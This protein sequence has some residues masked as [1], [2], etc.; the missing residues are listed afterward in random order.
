M[1][2]NFRSL[3]VVLCLAALL[4][5]CSAQ[6][7]SQAPSATAIVTATPQPTEAVTPE[8]TSTPVIPQVVSITAVPD[9]SVSAS[10]VEE[11]FSTVNRYAARVYHPDRELYNALYRAVDQFQPTLDISG[12]DLSRQQ[13]LGTCESLYVEGQFRFFYLEF[14]KQSKD[15]K[16]ITFTYRGTKEEAERGKETFYAKF[17]HLLHNVARPDGTDLQKY[18]AVYQYLCET[19]SYSSDMTDFLT[20]SPYSILVKGQGICDGYAMLMTVALD[21]LGVPVKYIANT[22]HAWNIVTIDNK[23][24]HGDVTWGAGNTTDGLNKLDTALMDDAARMEGLRNAG[25]EK[26]EI[27]IG[28]PGDEGAPAVPV[29][30]STSFQAYRDAVYYYALDTDGQKIYFARGYQVMSMNLDCTDEAVLADQPAGRMAFYHGTLYFVDMNDGFLYRLKPGSKPEVVDK[31]GYFTYLNI[32]RGTHQYGASSEPAGLKTLR[33]TSLLPGEPES[34]QVSR[35]QE[36]VVPR[37]RSFSTQIRFSEP[38]DTNA[39][40]SELVYLVD[41]QGDPIPLHFY[42]SPDGTTLTVRPRECVADEGA[43]D[44]YLRKEAP[45][46]QGAVMEAGRAMRIMIQAGR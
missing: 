29:C 24:Y 9:Q 26:E 34:E 33:L 16:T 17:S 38:M 27:M 35:L 45:S 2:R 42:W 43:V 14:A 7:H 3:L 8:P 11:P 5:G 6:V 36:A 19:S 31:S 39:D 32:H 41:R 10:D 21:S 12:F 22:S 46:A 20:F 4:A 13:V 44:L 25:Y 28:Y 15:G 40:W 23:T 18:L 1:K 37:S 30:D